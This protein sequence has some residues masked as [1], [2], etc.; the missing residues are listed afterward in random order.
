MHFLLFH[1]LP[2]THSFSEEAF[3]S[4]TSPPYRAAFCELEHSLRF[5]PFPLWLLLHV[6]FFLFVLLLMYISFT[7]YIPKPFILIMFALEVPLVCECIAH[8]CCCCCCFFLIIV[9]RE[10]EC[11]YCQI[12]SQL[13]S[14]FFPI[15][16][17]IWLFCM[18]EI[19]SQYQW[20]SFEAL[21]AN[22]SFISHSR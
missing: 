21:S 9:F 2:S 1:I 22:V 17:L 11:T 12:F 13:F 10:I 19:F 18:Q 6:H 3:S 14:C 5:P 7:V 15:D 8:C 20:K 16:S 4:P